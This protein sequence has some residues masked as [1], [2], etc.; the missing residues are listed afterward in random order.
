[1][2]ISVSVLGEMKGDRQEL[3]NIFGNGSNS[4]V[5]VK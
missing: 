1:M 4:V 5:K 2:V 3:V